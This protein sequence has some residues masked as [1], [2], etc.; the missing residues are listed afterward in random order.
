MT[1]PE[2][3]MLCTSS[4]L[5]FIQKDFIIFFKSTFLI[6]INFN[7]DFIL[8]TDWNEND[9]FSKAVSV[10]VKGDVWLKQVKHVEK[11]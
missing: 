5:K 11:N 3:Q 7:Y 2:R 9:L 1:F 6:L 8:L 10:C 4:R